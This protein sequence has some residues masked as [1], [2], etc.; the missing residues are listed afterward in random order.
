MTTGASTVHLAIAL[1]IEMGSRTDGPST[2]VTQVI[3]ETVYPH[4]ST[5]GPMA[6][7]GPGDLVPRH[8]TAA[9]SRKLACMPLPTPPVAS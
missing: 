4:A 9:F 7:Q 5:A 3:A 2:A 6:S 1:R 8:P